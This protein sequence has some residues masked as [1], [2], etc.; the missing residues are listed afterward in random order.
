MNPNIAVPM[1]VDRLLRVFITADASGCLSRL[2]SVKRRLD[3]EG[4]II[5]TP[6]PIEAI[7][8]TICNRV[9]CVLK[10]LIK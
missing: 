10:V 1:D 2:M 5:P 4:K 9:V 7:P 6:N 3:E 8:N